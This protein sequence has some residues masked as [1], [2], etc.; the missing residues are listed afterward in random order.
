MPIRTGK[1]LAFGFEVLS[2]REPASIPDRVED[3]LSLESALVR[4]FRSFLHI[5]G[6][7]FGAKATPEA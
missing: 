7:T 3:G 5:A 6:E 4:K 1:V 2:S